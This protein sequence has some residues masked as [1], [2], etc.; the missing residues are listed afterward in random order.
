MYNTPLFSLQRKKIA[1]SGLLLLFVKNKVSCT[2][3]DKF[4][5]HDHEER[6]CNL[7]MNTVIS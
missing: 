3:K 4:F 5:Y 7:Y 1:N 6:S 2:M